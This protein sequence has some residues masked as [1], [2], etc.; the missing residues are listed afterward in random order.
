MDVS[1][2]FA[3]VVP[4][5]DRGYVNLHWHRPGKGMPGR[6]CRT[7][8]DLLEAIADA[9]RLHPQDDLYFCISRQML[10]SGRRSR[11][12]A[13]YLVCVPMDLDVKPGA[14]ETVA[15]AVAAILWFCD[16][17][18]IPRPSAL[19]MSGGGVHAYWFSDRLLTVAEWQPYAD[20]L[21]ATAKATGV[22]FDAN[23]TGDAARV[24]R[25]PGT[26]NWKIPGKPR[27]VRL[28][29]K[30]CTGA[31]HDFAEVFKGI[32]KPAPKIT[33]APAFQH[34]KAEPEEAI[35]QDIPPLDVAPILTGCGWLREAYTT[36][37]AAFDNPQWNLT[38]LIATFLKGGQA[39]A[40]TFG[41]GHPDYDQAATEMEWARKNRER[42]RSNI[43]WP[44][45]KT[46]ADAGS[47]H[48][49]TCAF[50]S[51]DKTPIHIAYEAFANPVDED[52]QVLGGS[53]PPEMRLPAGYCVN[54]EGQICAIVRAKKVKG[55]IQPARLVTL[56]MNP[57]HTPSLQ[58]QNNR[59][60]LGF[61]AKTDRYGSSEVFL[62]SGNCF[63]EGGLFRHLAEKCVLYDPDDGTR[64]MTEKFAVA[65]LD[66]LLREDTAVRDTGTMGWRYEAG[67]RVGFVY[68]NTLYHE[69]GKEIEL[70]ASTDN[71]FRSWYTPVGSK[72]AWLQA[73]KLLTDRKRPELDIIIAI[74]FAAPLMAFAGTLYGA[75]LSV[76]GHPGTAKSTAQQVAASVWGHPKQTRES[77]NSTPKSIQKR[78]GLC[79]NLAAYWDDIQDER[80]QDALFQTMF[81]ATQGAEG[82]RLNTDTS[83]RE[84][85]D[86]QTLLVACSNASFVEYLVRKQ[87][88]TTAGMRR[89]FEIELQKHDGEPGMIDATDANRVFGALEQNYG[90]IGA[91]YAKMLAVDHVTIDLLVAEAMKA[92]CA[93]VEGA[94][95]EAYWWGICGVLL[96]GAMFANRLGAELDV[97]AMEAHLKEAFHRNRTIRGSEGTE[98]GTYQNTELGL[99][100]FLNHYVGSGHAIFVN[101]LFEHRHKPIDVL[102]EP[103]KRCPIVVQIVRDQRKIIFSKREMREYLQRKEVQVR[104]IFNGLE[105]YFKATEVRHTL[106]AGTVYSQTQEV[107]IEILVPEGRPHI[108][109]NMLEALGPSGPHLTVVKTEV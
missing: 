38:T 9:K 101:K 106:G 85:L 39:L 52:L 53:R 80:H 44:R 16:Y 92:F 105:K 77:L 60:G 28:L 19:V 32:H 21:K 70:V 42:D 97:V 102:R 59:F 82:G 35:L 55:G 61:V 107:C 33:V 31:K 8:A 43:G 74:G 2:F 88:S 71:D 57:I 40:H 69:D 4:W 48:C 99:T 103:E 13:I 51:K 63:R 26:T 45:C 64:K 6:S 41:R 67:K 58:F 104:Q 29:P 17:I 109:A 47:T 7:L 96:A 1:D 100:G 30:Y 108:L 3:N 86:W 89:V 24:L 14:Y 46:I 56:L 91:E 27:P 93:K 76:W 20:A 94:G 68:G 10:N 65:W 81:V 75:I 37:G 54:E 50:R 72:A 11:E 79:R 95:D 25:V 12:H 62:H 73:A 87:K 83:M 49:A 78:L 36:G 90:V 18:G 23:C 15:E 98:G 5:D 34:L 22:L 84:R 66:K